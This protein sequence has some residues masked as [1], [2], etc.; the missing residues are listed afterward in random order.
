MKLKIYFSLI[1]L[2]LI[3]FI[4]CERK[5]ETENWSPEIITPLG[6]VKL[7]LGDLIPQEGSVVYDETNF[8][9]L[10]YRDDNNFSFTADSVINIPSQEG[11]SQ[12]YSFADFVIDDFNEELPYTL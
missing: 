9:S 4:S 11:F 7:T 5:I 6:N 8:I 2:F 10:A 3:F 1:S 12:Y